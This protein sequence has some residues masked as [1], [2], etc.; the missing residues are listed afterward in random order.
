MA[1]GQWRERW[2]CTE[3]EIALTLLYLIWW[4]RAALWHAMQSNAVQHLIN[5]G[6]DALRKQVPFLDLDLCQT[7]M[8]RDALARGPAMSATA[9]D[10]DAFCSFRARRTRLLPRG[11]HGRQGSRS[12]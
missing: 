8:R 3:R 4:L 12:R 11:C 6:D 1:R 2:R 5:S 7:R 10:T 9:N